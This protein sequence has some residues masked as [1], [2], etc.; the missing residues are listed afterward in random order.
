[1]TVLIIKNWINETELLT[2]IILVK[3][4]SIV[5]TVIMSVAHK[6]LVNAS[7]KHSVPRLAYK[8][9]RFHTRHINCKAK[10]LLNTVK[11]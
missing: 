11:R 3:P 9:V 5:S 6:R 4:N 8:A 1:M 10:N 2:T 7:L